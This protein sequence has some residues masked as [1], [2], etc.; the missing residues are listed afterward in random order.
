M[1]SGFL[2]DLVRPG[3]VSPYGQAFYA[4]AG[5]EA[6]GQ[7][8]QRVK[9]VLAVRQADPEITF[10][11]IPDHQAFGSSASPCLHEFSYRIVSEDAETEAAYHRA[12]AAAGEACD[13]IDLQAGD[14]LLI[15]NTR[16][17]HART[18]FEAQQDGTDRWLLKTFVSRGGWR[19]SDSS[20]SLEW[21]SFLAKP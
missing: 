19:R 2:A 9:T 14:A 21:P 15:D 1:Q 18:A 8:S 17:N 10:F 12:L 4:V 11:Y 16:C 7:R 3:G 20:A 6:R 5:P 13:S